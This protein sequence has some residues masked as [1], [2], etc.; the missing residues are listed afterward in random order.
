MP[1]LVSV[2]VALSVLSTGTK[3]RNLFNPCKILHNYD[4][5]DYPSQSMLFWIIIHSIIII[6]II[7]VRS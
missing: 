6:I 1:K 7:I 2:N 4:I 3:S 5:R